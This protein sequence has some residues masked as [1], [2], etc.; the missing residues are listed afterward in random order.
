MKCPK[1]KKDTL[2]SNRQWDEEFDREFDKMHDTWET[3]DTIREKLERKE[4][5]YAKCE[6]SDCEHIQMRQPWFWT[7]LIILIYVTWKNKLTFYWFSQ[8]KKLSG[9]LQKAFLFQLSDKENNRP[10]LRELLNY[11]RENDIIVVSELDRLGATLEILNLPS[12]NGIQD[13]NLR[14]LPNNLIANYLSIQLK[15][16]VSRYLKGKDNVLNRQKEKLKIKVSL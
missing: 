1:C 8:I 11:I 10:K 7:E 6:N 5:F 2:K 13:D 16:S 14:R 12:L 15:M 9:P 4:I 3:L